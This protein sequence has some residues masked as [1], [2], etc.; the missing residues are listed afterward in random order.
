MKQTVIFL[1]LLFMLPAFG[2]EEKRDY[3]IEV[4]AG[5]FGFWPSSKIYGAYHLGAGL[6]FPAKRAGWY[7]NFSLN[8]TR[9]GGFLEHYTDYYTLTAGKNRQWT[10][11]HFYSSLGLNA[12]LYFGYPS[13]DVNYYRWI[14][15]GIALHPRGEIGWAGENVKIAFGLYVSM[16]FGYYNNP[17][18]DEW[19]KHDHW[20]RGMGGASPYLKIIF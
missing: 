2:Q 1:F 15:T 8:L 9:N 7:N 18:M 5:A 19:H 13:F 17:E 3:Q 10:K 20:F 11:G 14:N 6:N 12:G 16:G 4:S